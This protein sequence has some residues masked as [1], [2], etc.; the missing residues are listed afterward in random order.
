MNAC[1]GTDGGT[2]GEQDPL[3]LVG[4]TL[5]HKY[6]MESVVR[7]EAGAVVYRATNLATNRSIAI[8]VLGALA[9]LAPGKQ[10]RSTSGSRAITKSSMS[11]R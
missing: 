9:Q 10:R 11:W 5:A 1:A 2:H 6:A 7:I 8:R 4:T 3:H